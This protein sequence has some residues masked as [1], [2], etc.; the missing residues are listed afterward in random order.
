[1]TR[2]LESLNRGT[3]NS[4]PAIAPE[5]AVLQRA[6]RTTATPEI[7]PDPVR[8][9]L[10]GPGQPLPPDTRPLME[11][12]F[13]RDFGAV[14]VHTDAAAQRSVGTVD[15]L[16]YTAGPH[17][18][19]GP[20]RFAPGTA[21]GKQLIAHELA[22]VV[23]HGER[24]A[25]APL[26][27]DTP[28]ADRFEQEAQRAAGEVVRGQ[29]A[30]VTAGDSGGRVRRN[31][32]GAAGASLPVVDSKDIPASWRKTPVPLSGGKD[33][34]VYRGVPRN[35]S[36]RVGNV[37][38]ES[39]SGGIMSRRV[40]AAQDAVFNYVNRDPTL[41][42]EN[43]GGVLRVRIPAKVWDELVQTN[44]I[45]ERDGYPGFSRQINSTELRV[46]S[47]EAG[48]LINGQPT[49]ILPPDPH[50]DFRQG[51]TR[52]PRPA[53]PVEGEEPKATTTKTTPTK[54]PK[55]VPE[56]EHA[57]E[58][59]APKTA[60]KV[61][62]TKVRPGKLSGEHE[63]AGEVAEPKVVGG[64]KG[65]LG[66]STGS[67]AGLGKGGSTAGVVAAGVALAVVDAA[68][69]IIGQRYIQNIMDKKN[70]EAFEQKLRDRQ[71]KIEKM[72][73]QQEEKAKKLQA[74]GKQIYATV[75]LSVQYQT[76]SVDPSSG[77]Q[78]TAFMD[79]DVKSV[80]IGTSKLDKVQTQDVT[81]WWQGQFGQTRMELTFSMSY[82]Q[83][84]IVS[85]PE[86]ALPPPPCFIATACY[87]S[88]L[89][90]EVNLLRA[91][92]DIVLIPRPRG[93]QFV[94]TYYRLS[95]PVARWISPSA[96]RR[97]IVRTLIVGPIVA[98]LSWAPI[99]ARWDRPHG[100]AP[101]WVYT[102][103]LWGA[104]NQPTKDISI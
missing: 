63:G 21:A 39:D 38:R 13:G 15:A 35:A 42:G 24:M 91:F 29:P 41:S 62:V 14:R 79:L 18:A 82:P 68:I 56:G 90:D 50:Y 74:E 93:R 1:M 99:R 83:L 5:A 49:D 25:R 85:Q 23:Q 43:K 98:V 64:A 69:T 102:N 78:I 101:N 20:G 58:G 37:V 10:N 12:R 55:V 100:L 52:P 76:G 22:H 53:M 48:R 59:E 17:I 32:K 80:D 103:A 61:L 19:F 97:A 11:S 33:V 86:E 89:T 94:R 92:R 72:V 57:G 40:D 47:P 6:A 2:S 96:L 66:K 75:T 73:A 70:A 27:M 7:A 87:G 26:T 4:L 67:R 65:G 44:S 60:P 34:Y 51:A 45:S 3:H 95:P 8:E 36:S 54:T 28:A 77:I 81:K 31:G 84:E 46:N 71:P 104:P 9:P 30:R 16:A 88:P